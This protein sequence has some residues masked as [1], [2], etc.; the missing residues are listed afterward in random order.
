MSHLTLLLGT[1]WPFCKLAAFLM[2][3]QIVLNFMKKTAIF[4]DS[5]SFEQ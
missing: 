3:D 1:V 5:E 2:M 4:N